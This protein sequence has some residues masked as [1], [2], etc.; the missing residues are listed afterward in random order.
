MSRR[1]LKPLTRR[2][3]LLELGRLEDWLVVVLGAKTM[4][5]LQ[6]FGMPEFL[7]WMR[8]SHAAR[9]G[10]ALPSRGSVEQTKRI[11]SAFLRD[12]AKESGVPMRESWEVDN[13]S[14]REIAGL[15]DTQAMDQS[16]L[17]IAK[18]HSKLL[19][20]QSGS[21]YPVGSLMAN[22]AFWCC[23]HSTEIAAM[24]Q[25]DVKSHTQMVRLGQGNQQR[26]VGVPEHVGRQL[27]EHLRALPVKQALLPLFPDGAGKPLKSSA[28]STRVRKAFGRPDNRRAGPRQLRRAF[29]A[30]AR[31]Q[32]VSGGDLAYRAG[33]AG[34]RASS[35]SHDFPAGILQRIARQL[36]T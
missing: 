13:Q 26:D 27:S 8:D 29:L 3:Y 32:P 22:L 35:S 12:W 7:C 15:V 11:V 34:I 1:D 9:H 14:L 4:S 6:S 23:A 33:N 25:G 30:L 31:P 24:R 16:C 19:L 10:G 28:V 36:Q 17:E 21:E 20:G 5:E 18:T 2:A